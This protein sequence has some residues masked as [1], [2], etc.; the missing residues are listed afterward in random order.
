MFLWGAV[1][2][3]LSFGGALVYAGV[4][5]LVG[6]AKDATP[7]EAIFWGFVGLAVGLAM[8]A[9]AAIFGWKLLP[10]HGTARMR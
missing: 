1:A 8:L 10:T 9:G 7:F 2:F 4:R 3:G 6:A 5:R